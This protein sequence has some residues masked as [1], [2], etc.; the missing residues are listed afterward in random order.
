MLECVTLTTTPMIASVAGAA[1]GTEVPA[2]AQPWMTTPGCSNQLGIDHVGKVGRPEHGLICL[3]GWS[4][5]TPHAL[6][7]AQLCI[8]MNHL[9]AAESFSMSLVRLGPSTL[10][11]ITLTIGRISK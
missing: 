2:E 4:T 6:C 1:F 11:L 7:A 5:S 9:M 8:F 3:S 10:V